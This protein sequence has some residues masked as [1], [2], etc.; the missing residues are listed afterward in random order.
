VL[1]REA[2]CRGGGWSARR[3]PGGQAG[4]RHPCDRLLRKLGG[5]GITLQSKKAGP[6]DSGHSTSNFTPLAYELLPAAEGYGLSRAATRGL[7][8]CERGYQTY[9]LVTVTRQD[10]TNS[11]LRYIKGLQ[12]A[13]IHRSSNGPG[14]ARGRNI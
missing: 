3:R 11:Q 4:S 12:P 8:K 14:H 13:F 7:R 10:F 6:R 1:T 9:A 2:F 5:E